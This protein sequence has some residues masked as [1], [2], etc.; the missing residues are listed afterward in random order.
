MSY[1]LTAPIAK[2]A[3]LEPHAARFR[4]SRLTSLQQEF[5]LIPISDELR[6]EIAA[7][8]VADR[9]DPYPE[10]DHLSAALADWTL[11]I[12]AN[13]PVTYV[14]VDPWAG[15]D[16]EAA[17]PWREGRV[18]L[19]ALKPVS[20]HKE[21]SVMNEQLHGAVE[22]RR[23]TVGDEERVREADHLFDH[24]SRL[25]AAQDF[26]AQSTNYLLIAYVDGLPAGMIIGHE[27]PRLDDPRP[28]LFLYEVG[29]DE[30][31]RRRG[32]GAALVKALARMGEERNCC[33]MFVLTNESNEP[34][35]RLYAS[36]G[37]WRNEERDI[38][39]FEWAWEQKSG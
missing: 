29:V 35:M 12:S 37:G 2:Q 39:M 20:G 36:T 19:G 26:L 1:A 15:A 3:G 33:E 9:P 21:G 31:H 11:E 23:L 27:L 17:I 4:S 28:M 34:A 25:Q 16:D 7:C 6:D 38:A 13:T 30:A 24:P 22:I 18:A 8:G 5:A 14:E 32:L 10:F